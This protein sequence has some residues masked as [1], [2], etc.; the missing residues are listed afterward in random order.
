MFKV[1][2]AFFNVDGMQESTGWDFSK[3]PVDDEQTLEDSDTEAEEVTQEDAETV[4]DNTDETDS[5]TQE[6]TQEPA[7]SDETEIEL[8]DDRQP[9]KLAEL[10]QGYLR[11]SDYT[12]KTQALSEER[13]TFESERAQWEPVKGMHDFLTSNP[14][15]NQQIEQFVKE[16]TSTGSISLEDA[17]ADAQYGQYINSLLAQTNQL[18]K[19]LE[20][21]KGKVGELEFTG[22]MRDLKG[23]LKAEYGDLAT[24]E[25]L[26]TIEQRAKDEKLPLNVLKEIAETQLSKKKLEQTQAEVKK[27]RKQTEAETIKTLQEQRKSASPAPGRQGQRPNNEEVDTSKDWGSFLRA[28][29]TK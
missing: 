29:A 19:E 20:S 17:L 6:E 22:T 21:Y 3:I 27:T 1:R 4:E 14:W 24:D 9:V 8:G 25:Y 2:Q 11:Q 13:K 26:Q 12:K 5:E 10:K 18:T 16:F 15:L 23:E 7:F 28:A